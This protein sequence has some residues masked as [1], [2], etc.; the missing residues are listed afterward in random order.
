MP[1]QT[2]AE[3]AHE[4]WPWALVF[5][6]IALRAVRRVHY[7]YGRWGIGRPWRMDAEKSRRINMGAGVE[8]ADELTVC[9]AITQEFIGS[10]SVAGRWVEAGNPTEWYFQ[11]DREQRWYTKN[12]KEK[13]DIFIRKF[14]AGD[15]GELGR[16]DNDRARCVAGVTATGA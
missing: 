5:I 7:E 10:P 11:I 9:A 12:P 6:E 4:E 14:V 13:V 2:T 8:L 16:V 1:H 15:G 3:K